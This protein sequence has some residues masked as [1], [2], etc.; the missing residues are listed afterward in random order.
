MKPKGY[1]GFLIFIMAFIFLFC[2]SC[3]SNNASTSGGNEMAVSQPDNSIPKKQESR[4][5][6]TK[7]GLIS[8]S[9]DGKGLQILHVDD[10]YDGDE[11]S[12]TLKKIKSTTNLDGLT[13]A[14][15]TDI[16]NLQDI[17]SEGTE[18]KYVFVKF[19]IT[20]KL[21]VKQDINMNIKLGQDVSMS[22]LQYENAFAP[23]Y[24]NKGQSAKKDKSNYSKY[25][26]YTLDA[27]EETDIEI[28]Y[29]V[30]T[31]F[32]N[33]EFYIFPNCSVHQG[34]PANI[35]PMELQDMVNAEVGFSFTVS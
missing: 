12:F 15:K 22:T 8:Q 29:W 32:L 16:Q 25:F 20:N 33:K 13:E 7:A 24:F 31:K 26:D 14:E 34:T 27:N 4:K 18:G 17:V 6:N 35:T 30:S 9:S 10:I 5:D 2:A 1:Y 3:G 19:T 23:I 11:L 28:G 21:S